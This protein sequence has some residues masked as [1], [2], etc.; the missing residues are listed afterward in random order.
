MKEAEAAPQF[1][2]TEISTYETAGHDVPLVLSASTGAQ[3]GTFSSTTAP[4]FD[5]GLEFTMEKG[6]LTAIQT[7]T[8]TEVWSQ[9]ADGS[10]DSAPI[11]VGGSVYVGGSSGLVASFNENTGA[12]TWSAN[13][14]SPIFVPDEQ[15]LS[16]E[17]T[18]LGAGDGLLV[19]PA[20]D[21]LVAFGADDTSD[22]PS[23]GPPPP[24]PDPSRGQ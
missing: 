9:T 16:D 10:L 7:S 6:T 19:V 12:E 3:L 5:N 18:G 21:T 11:V 13:A 15:N 22:P 14:G 2:T 23:P 4:A 17:L 24:P 1:C 20:S 8:G